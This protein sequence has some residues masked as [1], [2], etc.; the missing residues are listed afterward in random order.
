[1]TLWFSIPAYNRRLAVNMAWEEAVAEFLA[2]ERGLDVST[3]VH[4]QVTAVMAV[5]TVRAAM[6]AE[7]SGDTR[8]IDA[9]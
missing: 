6:R 4:S 3:D 9:R 1:M 2:T 7:F 8:L 5:G